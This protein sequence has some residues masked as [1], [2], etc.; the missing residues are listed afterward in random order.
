MFVQKAK[1][2]YF[3]EA[4][5]ENNELFTWHENPI[6]IETIFL[7]NIYEQKIGAVSL[8]TC[9]LT[10]I[11]KSPE[12]IL[13]KEH[14]FAIYTLDPIEEKEVFS[15][16]G[17][18]SWFLDVSLQTKEVYKNVTGKIKHS[19]KIDEKNELILEIVM[20]LSKVPSTQIN[21]LNMIQNF[22]FF[23]NLSSSFISKRPQNISSEVTEKNEDAFLEPPVYLYDLSNSTNVETHSNFQKSQKATLDMSQSSLSLPLGNLSDAKIYQSFTPTSFLEWTSSP[24]NEPLSP[25]IPSLSSSPQ[26]QQL[27]PSSPPISSYENQISYFTSD[28]SL[29][30]DFFETSS[31]INPT[32]SPQKIMDHMQFPQSGIGSKYTKTKKDFENEKP[33]ENIET[34]ESLHKNPI[35]APNLNDNEPS[36]DE[37]PERKKLNEAVRAA[38][39]ALEGLSIIRLTDNQVKE[40]KIVTDSS[41]IHGNYNI[42][43]EVSAEEFTDKNNTKG[44]K[45]SKQSGKKISNA[46]RVEMNLLKSIQEG[47]IPNY[48]NNC[49]TI[50]TVSW[51]RVKTTDDRPEETLCNPCGVWWSSHKSMRPSYLWREE[52]MTLKFHNLSS[53]SCSSK[54]TK[55]KAS[56]LNKNNENLKLKA[57]KKYT[58]NK[59]SHEKQQNTIIVDRTALS[60][61]VRPISQEITI[62]EPFSELNNENNCL[63]LPEKPTLLS[64]NN[65]EEISLGSLT[66]KENET[67]EKYCLKKNTNISLS[68]TQNNYV[69]TTPEKNISLDLNPWKPKTFL[70]QSNVEMIDTFIETQ[71]DYKSSNHCKTFDSI[72]FKNELTNTTFLTS[73]TFLEIP[74]DIHNSKVINLENINLKESHKL[75]ILS[76]PPDLFMSSEDVRDTTDDLWTESSSSPNINN[77]NIDN[78]IWLLENTENNSVHFDNF[79]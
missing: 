51:R 73:S 37:L 47:K 1:C 26:Y 60:S 42:I 59:V 54:K 64:I 24:I 4:N 30:Q 34:F 32:S 10:V 28:P 8:K 63:Y 21:L 17:M 27:P 78:K 19:T 57:S 58:E 13:Q 31:F 77:V 35:T 25:Q 79:F 74:R 18:L 6:S 5:I 56:C 7:N 66:G 16:Q 38:K 41:E 49:G 55:R 36:N 39:L 70:P 22:C 53:T 65:I 29:S 44:D 2:K 45:S 3:L 75:N 43:F 62:R 20:R 33:S 72:F 15:G 12:L 9:L 40:N 23:H 48:C 46:L 14:D 61:P 76:S 71:K 69:E 68:N 11:S 50:K 52:S 67:S